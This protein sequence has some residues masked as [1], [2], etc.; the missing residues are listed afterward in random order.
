M[1]TEI[2]QLMTKPWCCLL[3]RFS[4]VFV[5]IRY[6]STLLRTQIWVKWVRK[7]YRKNWSLGPSK[8]FYLSKTDIENSPVFQFIKKMPKGAALHTHHIS[9]GSIKWIVSNL[10]YWYVHKS[11]FLQCILSYHMSITNPEFWIDQFFFTVC[12]LCFSM[13]L[14]FSIEIKIDK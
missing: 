9:L 12:S 7:S 5:S 11:I 14:K 3:R 1:V 4:A 8:S 10:T 2:W 6:S 13:R